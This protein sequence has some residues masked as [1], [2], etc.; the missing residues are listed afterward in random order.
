M[1]AVR[2]N[3]ATAPDAEPYRPELVESDEPRY[4]RR[5]KPVE[6]RRKKFG[7]KGLSFYRSVF[8][9][10]AVAALLAGT[11]YFAGDFLLHS[12]KVLLLKP[13]QVEVNG[14]HL[15]A[16]DA[17][18]K[19]FYKDRGRSVLRI[20]LNARRSEIEQISWV[21]T[22]SVQRVLPNRIRVDI[23]ERTPIAFLR[24]GSELALIDPFGVILDR[25][26]G[27][28]LRFPIV[29]GLADSM[30]RAEREKRMQ[31]YQEFLRDAD[32]V[33]SG[34][35]DFVSEVDLSNPADFRVVMA[36][37]PK[38]SVAQAVTIHFGSGQ[39]AAKYRLLV[40]NFAQW[41]ANNGCVHSVDLQY[42]RQI[43]LNPDSN[44]CG[45]HATVPKGR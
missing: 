43:V 26:Q 24:N 35:S 15:V 28:D 22:A 11:A 31:T 12:P 33:R 7:G 36:G 18:R 9:W 10:T 2:K 20:P 32:V 38:V 17:V 42:E 13:D 41:Q 6:I 39:Y 21:Q 14:N 37:L 45:E 40:E 44:G 4:L 29:T 25:P 8:L 34:S 27:E 5:Q 23:S 19:P 3:A 16:R 1:K 30:P